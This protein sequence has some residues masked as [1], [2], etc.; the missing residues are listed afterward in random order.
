MN[1]ELDDAIRDLKL[2]V[3]CTKNENS[4][5]DRFKAVNMKKIIDEV[6]KNA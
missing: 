1:D 6:L 2:I 3:D 5:A 4:N